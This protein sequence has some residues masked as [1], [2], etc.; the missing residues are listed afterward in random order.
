MKTNIVWRQ[1]E[2]GREYNR[3]IGLYESVTACERFYRGDQ[4]RSL[5][6]GPLPTPVFNYIRRITDFLITQVSYTN[7]DIVYSDENL[8]FVKDKHHRERIEAAVDLL[9]R[10]AAYRWDKCRLDRVVRTALL[11]AA[12]S[13]DGVFFTY[14]DP[15]VRTGQAYTGDFV[16][17]TLDSTNLFV[18]N[19]NSSDIQSQEY[20]MI[21]G[22]ESAAKLKAEA[23]ASGAPR[24]DAERI[25]PDEDL[26]YGAGDCAAYE[27]PDVSMEKATYVLKF[28][29]DENG[30]VVFEKWTKEC[31]IKRVATAQRLYPVCMFNWIPVKNSYH[32]ASPV[33]P[34]IQ[35]QKYIN[36][37]YALA[38][39]HM[40][41]TAFSKVVYDKTRVPEWSNE[42]G[43]AIGVVGGDIHGVAAT[44]EAGEMDERFCQI[45][46]SV[47][48]D[49][50][51]SMG[52]T[53][54][55][56]GEAS[57][58]NT[59]AI[60]ALQE[61]NAITL[62]FVRNALFACLEELAA[63]W[64]DFMC[65]YYADGR[66]VLA[67]SAEAL[68]LDCRVLREELIAARVDVG[69]STRYSKASALSELTKLLSGGHITVKQYLER[70]PDGVIP[71]REALIDELSAANGDT[72]NAEVEDKPEKTETK[73]ES[74]A[75]I[76]GKR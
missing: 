16:T 24:N 23:I 1:F 68:S 60:V 17:V 12:L 33:K 65:A 40:I 21:S 74:E 66:M 45:V 39:K 38:M 4:W 11:D 62:D 25:L 59:S 42:V 43:Q 36:K 73:T 57:P 22:R 47:I 67:D 27:N 32:G 35:N 70:V 41:D 55:S 34:L 44:V 71:K 5:P 18:A 76:Y 31:L 61:S 56:L 2:A 58:S 6:T 72:D 64:V 29:R 50:K 20:I 10:H 49:T 28:Y 3:R 26:H 19:V 46:E 51:D 30:Y 54:A 7:V 13:G 52:A 63:I 8:P 69:T 53:D 75:M 15:T 9:N 14:W 37:A 48:Q